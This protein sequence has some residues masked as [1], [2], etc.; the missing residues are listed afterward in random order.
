MSLDQACSP[1]DGPS[2]IHSHIATPLHL[3]G[4]SF[5]SNGGGSR[6]LVLQ[7]NRSH[8]WWRQAYHPLDNNGPAKDKPRPNAGLRPR[9]ARQ[10]LR[11]GPGQITQVLGR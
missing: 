4:F 1:K 5:S 7:L 6:L 11:V 2:L 10:A 3:G 9:T 8:G